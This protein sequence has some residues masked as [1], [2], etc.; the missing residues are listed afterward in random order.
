MELWDNKMP[1]IFHKGGF[2]HLIHGVGE[3]IQYQIKT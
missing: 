1:E 2:N 3:E